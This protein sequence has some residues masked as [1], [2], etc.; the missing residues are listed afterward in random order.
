M[1]GKERRSRE[2]LRQFEIESKNPGGF[3][4]EWI[5]SGRVYKLFSPIRGEELAEVVYVTEE[6]CEKIISRAEQAFLFWRSLLRP[7][8]ERW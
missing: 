4:G 6:E 7:N 8:G 2:I 5:S 1:G 3:A